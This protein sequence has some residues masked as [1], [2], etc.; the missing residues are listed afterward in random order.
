MLMM[1]G[2]A[3][4][5]ADTRRVFPPPGNGLE[6]ERGDVAE[7]GEER[8]EARGRRRRAGEPV[9]RLLPSTASSSSGSGPS[10]EPPEAEDTPDMA[11]TEFR[12]P[13]PGALAGFSVVGLERPAAEATR[14]FWIAA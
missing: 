9:G 8:E 14:E 12:S 3:V 7:V 10:V 13:P 6:G 1:S 2:W 11:D 5:G 4:G